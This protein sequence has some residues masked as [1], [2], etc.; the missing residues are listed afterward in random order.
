MID[1]DAG[2]QLAGAQQI[3]FGEHPFIDFRSTYGPLTFYASYAAQ[4]IGGGTIAAELL[5]C[6]L[7]YSVAFLLIYCCA[8]RFGG[9]MPA[10]FATAIALVQL[11]RFYKYYIFLGCGLV[12]I[13]LYVYIRKPSGFRLFL[14]AVCVT[15]A[16]LYRPDQGAYAF[17]VAALAVL[18]AE[19]KIVRALVMLPAMILI[20]A[21]PWLI[22][23]IVRGGLKN[24]LLDSSVGAA[25]HAAGLSLPFPRPNF[26]QSFSSVANLS[27]SA[28]FVW[29]M[30]PVLATVVLLFRYQRFDRDRRT[31]ILVTI[32]YAFLCLLQSA[33]RSDPG[34]LIQAI[35]P[36]YV[37]VAF[38]VKMALS[39]SSG[40]R[41]IGGLVAVAG[42]AAAMMISICA[43]Y[44][45]GW[46][47]SPNWGVMH[48]Y[49][50]FYAHRPA[51]YV[52]RLRA[53][54]PAL[55]YLQLIDFV[56][57]QTPPH[58]RFLAMP[59][60][61]TLYYLTQR[62][63][64][65]G[66][67]LLAPGYFSDAADQNKMVET[68]QKQGDPLIVEQANG[69]GYDGLPAR[70]SRS[71]SPILFQYIDSHYRKI[72]GPPLPAGIDAMIKR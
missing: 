26:S 58:G 55:P 43:E 64:A 69:G 4:K 14:L 33:H 17:V 24:Y 52:A 31:M 37:L 70:K 53:T 71:F 5:L 47:A 48:D 20:A 3:S 9:T 50:Y 16:G 51:T 32:V 67:M 57:T 19:R 1:A 13:S 36:C 27:A 35:V 56:E 59:F 8:R 60:M 38:L 6:T 46:I 42:L 63:F 65:G 30:I 23:L 62:P 45:G 25:E 21:S 18:L 39:F 68:L 41:A 72:E 10:L 66:Q 15:I 29:W 54:Y 7:A 22:F 12:L 49:A 2:H 44:S 61:T 11:P 40:P 34:H 28:F